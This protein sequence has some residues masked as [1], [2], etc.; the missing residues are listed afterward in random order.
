MTEYDAI[1][2]AAVPY[3]ASTRIVRDRIAF[4]IGAWSGYRVEIGAPPT[5]T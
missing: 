2:L 1:V 3:V 5:I 4:E